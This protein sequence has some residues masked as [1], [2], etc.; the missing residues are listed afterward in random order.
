MTPIHLRR[1]PYVFW[2]RFLVGAVP[3]FIDLNSD[4]HRAAGVF[5]QV[6]LRALAMKCKK[7]IGA[8][9][10]AYR[11]NSNGTIDSIC[12]DCFRTVATSS[13]RQLLAEKEH[14][15][16][17]EVNLSAIVEERGAKDRRAE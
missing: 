7:Q 10:F 5:F 16:H 3:F 14:E 2:G 12:L 11:Q 1:H 8:H 17:C 9:Y 15:H 13:D 6:S 4:S